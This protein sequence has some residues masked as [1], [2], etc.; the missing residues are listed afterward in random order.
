MI[1]LALVFTI[2]TA[3]SESELA[4]V[5]SENNDLYQ[6]IKKNGIK[7][8]RFENP[9]TALKSIK[10]NASMMILADKYPSETN[11]ISDSFFKEAQK[12]EIRLY[13]EYPSYLPN[14]DVGEPKHTHW[15]RAVISSDIF[16]PSL[17]K[18]RILGINDCHFVPVKSEKSLIVV[19]KV[20]GLDSADYGLPQET[21]PI[22]FEHPDYKILV[23]TTKLSQFITARYTPTDDWKYVWNMILRWLQP[24][25]QTTELK[26]DPLVYPSYSK[27]E[28]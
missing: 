14:I 18:L 2:Y 17:P 11:S 3:I 27:D 7:I 19:A 26:W 20:A 12:K 25:F 5:C 16:E 10:E 8:Q 28:V 24:D 4:V 1:P 23:S 13:V 22:L 15:E 6:A 21:S 9:E